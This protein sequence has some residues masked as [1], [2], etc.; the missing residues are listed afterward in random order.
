MLALVGTGLLMQGVGDALDRTG[1]QPP[2]LPL[3]LCGLA[4]IVTACAW[5]L[6][7]ARASRSERIWICVILGLGLLTSY[8]MHRPLLLDSF[9]EMAHGTTLEGILTSRSFFPTNTILP[10]SPFYPGLELATASTRWLTGLPLALDQVIVLAAARIVVVLGVFLVV[11]RACRSSR[12]GGIGV[13]AYASNPQFYGFDAQY[14][15]ETLALAFAVA[16]VHLL[17]V[18]IDSTRPR[19]AR[20]F[21]LALGC[22]GALVLSHHLTAWLT[23]GFLVVWATGLY[24]TA[25]FRPRPASGPAVPPGT[26]HGQ[27]TPRDQSALDKRTT[28]RRMVQARIVGIAALVGVVIGGTWTAFVGSRVTGYVSPI[29]DDAYANVQSVVGQGHGNRQLFRNSA[30]GGSPHWE[31]ALMLGA[32]IFWCLILLVSL[33]SVIR[34]RSVRGGALRFLPAAIATAYPLAI[35]ANVSSN[36]KAVGERAMTFIFLGVAVIVGAWLARRLLKTRGIVE[37]LATVVI[38][39]ICF[40]GS[41]LLGG[42]PLPSYLPGPYRRRR[43]RTVTWVSLTGAGSLGQRPSTGWLPRGGRPRQ[44]CVAERY[45]RRRVSCAGGWTGQPVHALLR[46][47]TQPV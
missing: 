26:S 13:L 15:Y 10:V 41:M 38:A 42:G 36:S 22:I 21:A 5:R 1:H 2:A 30:G 12:A 25:R 34:K 47:P 9:D 46:S 3:F 6:T 45:R 17:F 28:S 33:Y 19:M 39:T 37:R 31:I 7:G 27:V 35:L 29:L 14:A 32:A 11:E 24:L 43:R 44:R 40:L 8:I 20:S 16:T 4:V 18:S 23:L